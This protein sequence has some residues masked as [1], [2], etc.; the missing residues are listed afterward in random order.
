MS[1]E[2]LRVLRTIE[3]RCIVVRGDSWDDW[4]NN[5]FMK[6]WKAM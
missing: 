5:Q 4:V 1:S 2:E 6:D 3:K